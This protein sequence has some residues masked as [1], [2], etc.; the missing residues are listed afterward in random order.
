MFIADD[1]IDDIPG[2]MLDVVPVITNGWLFSAAFNALSCD[3]GFYCDCAG[4]GVRGD[5]KCVTGDYVASD[6]SLSYRNPGH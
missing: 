1:G 5:L 4:S 3:I 2:A 6:I